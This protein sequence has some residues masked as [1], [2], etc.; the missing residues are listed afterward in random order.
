MMAK[1]TISGGAKEG[2]V[3]FQATVDGVEG[4]IK[5]SFTAA[6]NDALSKGDRVP[7]NY[8][9]PSKWTDV[10]VV[11]REPEPESLEDLD[12]DTQKAF[13]TSYTALEKA[14]D[15]VAKK[16]GEAREA[17][18]AV[19]RETVTIRGRFENKE[20]WKQFKAF[21]PK[22]LKEN[23]LGK[24]AVSEAYRAG[25]IIGLD[26]FN[27]ETMLPAGVTGNKGVNTAYSG[28]LNTIAGNAVHAVRSKDVRESLGIGADAGDVPALRIVLDAMGGTDYSFEAD[29]QTELTIEQRALADVVLPLHLAN[30]PD[31]PAVFLETSDGKFTAAK[32]DGEYMAKALTGLEGADELVS[33]LA[34]AMTAS[35]SAAVVADATADLDAAVSDMTKTAADHKL[36]FAQW[37][38][39]LAARHLVK[40]LFAGWNP[41]GSDDE[42]EAA[43]ARI[44][45]IL[46]NMNRWADAIIEDRATLADV[47][48]PEVDTPESVDDAEDAADAE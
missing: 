7:G 10:Y 40:V 22:A 24:N 4:D 8:D 16:E 48:N 28:T 11:N 20:T 32:S 21:A 39:D 35:A 19:A 36:G 34:R 3:A 13:K 42:Y 6:L 30:L 26:G 31:A 23:F 41:E 38:E 9:A 17:A 33:A 27:A 43:S 18:F 46:A 5:N 1:G 45:G 47:L 37:S 25:L 14:L 2:K 44:N 15:K 29:G 12:A